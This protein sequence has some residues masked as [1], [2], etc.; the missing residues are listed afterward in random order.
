MI[1][2]K[3]A[4]ALGTIVLSAALFAAPVPVITH[5]LP[6]SAVVGGNVTFDV[7]FANGGPD[8][9]FQPFIDVILP[10]Q[11]ADA[12]TAGLQCDGATFVSATMLGVIPANAPL[13][14]L[15]H[16]PTPLPCPATTTSAPVSVTHP[17][18][19]RGIGPVLIPAGAELVTILLPFGDYQ[20]TQPAAQ[21]RITA[22]F[23]PFADV[24]TPLDVSIRGGFALGATAV[25]DP[26]TDPPI[27]TPFL[28]GTITPV[29]ASIS[30]SF[31]G[32]ENETAAGP[33][34][35]RQYVLEVGIPPAPN[36]KLTNVTVVDCLPTTLTLLSTTAV[37]P[38]ASSGGP[39]VTEMWPTLTT[40]ATVTIGFYVNDAPQWTK[41]TLCS[42][43][44][45]NNASVQATWTP[46]DPRDA[47]QPVSGSNN[48]SATFTAKAIATQ[49][50]AILPAGGLVPGAQI[51]YTIDFQ[52][53]DYVRMGELVIKDTIS[54]GV[55]IV[56]T[57]SLRVGDNTASIPNTPMPASTFTIA[58]PVNGSTNCG[59]V[60]GGTL[61][62]A[63]ISDA[64]GI[65]APGK[66][67]ANALTGGL[68]ASPAGGGATGTLTYTAQIDDA[69]HF[70][71]HFA[72][73]GADGAA[74]DDGFVG[75][76]DPIFNGVVISGHHF[77]PG[78]RTFD[79]GIVCGDDSQACLRI[80]DGP[81]RKTIVG[82]NGQKIGPFD[83][84]TPPLP[85]FV[86]G[87]TITYELTKVIPSGNAQDVYVDDW[88]PL[89]ILQF[90][91]SVPSFL[92]FC[93]FASLMP[94]PGTVCFDTAAFTSFNGT[95]S[96]LSPNHLRIHFPP[97]HEQFTFTLTIRFTLPISNDPFA[98][99][100]LLTNEA[101]E[102]EYDSYGGKSCQT[103]LAIFELDEP[104]I[105]LHKGILCTPPACIEPV[106]GCTNPDCVFAKRRPFLVPPPPP[107]TWTKA[108]AGPCPRVKG[109]V[110]ST[111]YGPLVSTKNA[112]IDS[113]DTVTYAIVVEN[114]GH[115]SAFDVVLGDL[116]LP[117]LL[118]FA[119]LP[120]MVPG[121]ICV[122]RGD[123]AT[124]PSQ[125]T[126]I[127]GGISIA[128]NGTL[129]P[130]DAASGAN[131]AVITFDV[132]VPSPAAFGSC[133]S[134]VVNVSNYSNKPGGTN[135]VN[136]GF[137][138]Q[139]IA[140]ICVRPSLMVKNIVA[141]S[142]KHTS[143]V[144]TPLPLP[145]VIG[146]IVR[147]R[148]TFN[149]PEGTGSLVVHD[150][151]PAGLKF[152]GPAAVT[153]TGSAISMQHPAPV[154][155]AN[156]SGVDFDFGDVTN[157]NVNQGCVTVVIEFPAL[158]LNITTNQKGTKLQ[159]SFSVMLN[160]F[161]TPNS[162]VVEVV[163]VEPHLTVTK[164][165]EDAN[166]AFF[167]FRSEITNDSNVIA[168]DVVLTDVPQSCWTN[169]Q[170][171]TK[172]ANVK[173]NGPVFTIDQLGPGE[174][175]VV[176]YTLEIIHNTQPPIVFCYDCNLLKNVM[177][178][179]WTSLPGPSGTAPNA[180]LATVPDKSGGAADGER[181]GTSVNPPNTYVN[182]ASY[183]PCGNV[184]GVK[185]HDL[186][187]PFGVRDNDEPGL[188][189]WTITG[190]I[191]ASFSAPVA[192][193]VT[194]ADGSFCISL[195][196][197][198]TF[199]VCEQQLP[200]WQVTT[201][202]GGCAKVQGKV[203]T[204]TTLDFGNRKDCF[205]T[206]TG[207]VFDDKNANGLLD[208]SEPG[209]EGWDVY[210]VDLASG[211]KV[212][213]KSD[214]S[215][216]YQLFV[217]TGTTNVFQTNQPGWTPTLGVANF[218]FEI[219]CDSSTGVGHALNHTPPPYNNSANFG[220]HKQ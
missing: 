215:G 73:G 105:V 145:V 5:T 84:V 114:Q 129:A 159:N 216:V 175:A 72:G 147:Y 189:G 158:V 217:P 207:K 101:Q 123:G 97:I 3:A 110:N 34:F 87:D 27:L 133:S 160:G 149:V 142:E 42:E 16:T 9:G 4:F 44:I 201:P 186:H 180:T 94:A 200:T 146:E 36:N 89:P 59:P 138:G 58:Q 70:P 15:P 124:L 181:N 167:I 65:L 24:N 151:L 210:A 170:L 205:V 120:S 113:G 14:V 118:P 143:D 7:T 33:N 85:K 13:E 102:C 212:H 109:I 121:T 163:V 11:G 192:K 83:P 30:K 74:P 153:T 177:Q 178:V 202:A 52:V 191:D 218:T 220:N 17:L 100:L 53:A 125:V 2:R 148:L 93:G 112:P 117:S 204:T 18:A 64:M 213:A 10:A 90:P 54:D 61:L 50:S 194:A 137:T 209:L 190:T 198:F 76:N 184:C 103:A 46:A 75:K 140:A 35:P 40:S 57:P 116:M 136:A 162:N 166:S 130:F 63:R 171:A 96:V 196:G 176:R 128:L 187:A 99:G 56:G 104:R 174:T 135:F 131:V 139:D 77:S 154:G 8:P 81:F 95:V 19:D 165:V 132:K 203:G 69:Y 38:P 108:C 92:P 80:D 168:Y 214:A 111:N 22:R 206:I 179:T 25:N 29:Q 156:A 62:T 157:A 193:S 183:L 41:T 91:A 155:T 71:P 79:S 161:P 1:M 119:L 6:A 164:V 26:G 211:S 67:L 208:S 98:D 106:P 152:L 51:T 88:I 127:T 141:T 195:F 12:G 32:P 115:G 66:F 188:Q 122:R 107:P 47:A 21:I 45:F 39:C 197:G 182:T 134:N 20:Q 150:A 219:E 86:A 28:T 144:I 31:I 68:V 169:F 37:P 199:N 82:R 172:S 43:S 126:N 23:D 55:T 48:A 60:T 173:G 78:A 185:F 49:K